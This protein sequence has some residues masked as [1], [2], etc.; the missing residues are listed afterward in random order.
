MEPRRCRE[1]SWSELTGLGNT[2]E[3]PDCWLWLLVGMTGNT[4]FLSWH[5]ETAQNQ[6][7]LMFRGNWLVRS[8]HSLRVWPMLGYLLATATQLP[9]PEIGRHRWT[10]SIRNH[11]YNYIYNQ[12]II[13]NLFFPLFERGNSA[14]DCVW[15]TGHFFKPVEAVCWSAVSMSFYAL[16]YSSSPRPWQGSFWTKGLVVVIWLL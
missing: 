10:L 3:G 15:N 16:S 1:E 2:A 6:L 9:R 13:F 8:E 14:M 12:I 4:T 11:L 5:L 7:F